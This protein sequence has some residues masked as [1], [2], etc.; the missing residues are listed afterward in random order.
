MNLG[1][2]WIRIV[3]PS[4]AVRGPHWPEYLIEAAGLGTFKASP[5]LFATL[6]EHPRVSRSA[7]RCPIPSSGGSP[8][9]WPWV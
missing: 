1:E 4:S 5:C 9:G 6:L 8:W 2:P 7:A 3:R